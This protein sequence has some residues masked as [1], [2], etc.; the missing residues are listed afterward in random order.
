MSVL[1]AGDGGPE[2]EEAG[3]LLVCSSGRTRQTP[4]QG[5][6]GR[7]WPQSPD[8]APRRGATFP[9]GEGSGPGE[10]ELAR[11]ARRRLV[12]DG[13][14]PPAAPVIGAGYTG[15]GGGSRFGG[16]RPGEERERTHR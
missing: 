8:V 9:G 14:A 10:V 15:V 5:R 2:T 1:H 6:P 13:E 7:P 11:R 16:E 3:D 4:R 12:A